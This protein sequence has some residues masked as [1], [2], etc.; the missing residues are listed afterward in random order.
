M[1]MENILIPVGVMAALG[2]VFGAALALALKIF[3]VKVDPNMLK[4]L[5]LLPGVNCGACGSAGCAAF[6]E[7]LAKG[8]AVPAACTVSD[9]RSRK[10]LAKLLGL[11]DGKK[12][13]MLK[14]YLRSRYDMSPDDYRSKW[15]LPAD[16]PMVAPNHSKRRSEMAKK[17]GLGRGGKA[18]KKK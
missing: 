9:D 18:A 6:A 11:E 14:R 2:L 7:S 17:I 16:Y 4:I 13:T 5:S 3:A 8:E 1:M 12:V 15:G 10:E